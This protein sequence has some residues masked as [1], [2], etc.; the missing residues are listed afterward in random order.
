MYDHGQR[1]DHG[2]S[3]RK[4]IYTKLAQ[5]EFKKTETY[6]V[7]PL[8]RSFGV[9]CVGGSIRIGSTTKLKRG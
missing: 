4:A 9:V 8:L 2:R 1:D 5:E 6:I 3:M 7:D